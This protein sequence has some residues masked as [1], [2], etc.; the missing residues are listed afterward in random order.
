MD[1]GDHA[2]AFMGRV[3]GSLT[4]CGIFSIVDMDLQRD[5][6]TCLPILLAEPLSQLARDIFPD[7]GYLMCC[8]V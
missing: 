2:R 5:L 3:G 4:L 1:Q 6:M 8:T 7:S